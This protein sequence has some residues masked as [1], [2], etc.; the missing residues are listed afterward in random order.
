MKTPVFASLGLIAIALLLSHWAN[1]ARPTQM[2]PFA[3]ATLDGQRLD[4]A[5]LRGHPALITFWSVSCAPC[6]R[7]IPQLTAL[8][9]D[10]A[11]RGLIVVG[12]NMAYD[13]A[14]HVLAL[15]QRRRLP[16]P[17]ALDPMGK[18]AAAFGN[19]AATPTTFLFDGR[20]RRVARFVGSMDD[21]QLRA[22]I[23]SLLPV[24]S[25]QVAAHPASLQQPPAHVVD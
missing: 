18:A 17:I 5:R 12:I 4:N 6:L 13:P 16:Y 25:T 2:P 15:V 10:L 11:A 22:T 24:A 7:E 8:Y 23:Q 14:D 1:P 21:G 9:R 19:I 20:G 3:L